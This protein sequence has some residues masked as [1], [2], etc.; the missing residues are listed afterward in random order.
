MKTE[1]SQQKL[2]EQTLVCFSFYSPLVP[3]F[4]FAFKQF[5]LVEVVE[6]LL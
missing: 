2:K 4:P 1:L 5:E 3:P 6:L